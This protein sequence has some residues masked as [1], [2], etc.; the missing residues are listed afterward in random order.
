MLLRTAWDAGLALGTELRPPAQS[1][2]K[3][4]GTGNLGQRA[5]S[6]PAHCPELVVLC[7][8]V[9]STPEVSPVL[10]PSVRPGEPK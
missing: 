7:S 2:P 1:S 10:S 4:G 8:P 6:S 3:G 9:T 5:T